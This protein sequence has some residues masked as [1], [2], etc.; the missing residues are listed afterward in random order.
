MN[1]WNGAH[2]EIDSARIFSFT[3]INNV[4]GNECL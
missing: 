4:D 1:S 3:I 2:F